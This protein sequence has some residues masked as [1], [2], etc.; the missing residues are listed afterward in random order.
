MIQVEREAVEAILKDHSDRVE[1][2]DRLWNRLWDR[3]RRTSAV[4]GLKE[5][6]LLA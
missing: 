5:T 6:I 1:L 2:L 3:Y 4:A